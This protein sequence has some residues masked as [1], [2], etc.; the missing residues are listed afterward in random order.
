[1]SLD[2]T[3]IA[4]GDLVVARYSW[5]GTHQGEFFGK[6]ATGNKVAVTGTSIYRI[7]GGK[8]VEERWQEDLLGLMQHIGG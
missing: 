3:L 6:P 1:M 5:R 2:V 7:A 8:I 4:E